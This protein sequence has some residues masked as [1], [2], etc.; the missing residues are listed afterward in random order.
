MTSRIWIISTIAFATL[1]LL[2][3]VSYNQVYSDYS[4]S[5]HS[6]NSVVTSYNSEISKN[7]NLTN[8]NSYL[9]SELNYSRN[10]YAVLLGNYSQKSYVYEP[11]SGVNQTF[12][13]WGLHENLPP[14][15]YITWMLLDTFQNHIQI[16]TTLP[17]NYFIFDLTSFLQFTQGKYSSAVAN[18]THSTYFSDNFI[19]TVGCSGYILVIQNPENVTSTI[20]PH[21]TATYSPSYMLTGICGG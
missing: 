5:V 6:Y 15:A 14:R 12:Q 20:I 21:V 2:I 1:C 9:Q 3:S 18:E 19:L 17:A 16:N 10:S 8:A 7:A 4:S 13:V 11:P